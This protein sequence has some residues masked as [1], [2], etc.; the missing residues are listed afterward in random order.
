MGEIH[1][2]IINWE[3]LETTDQVERISMMELTGWLIALGIVILLLILSV[4]FRWMVMSDKEIWEVYSGDAV[5]MYPWMNRCD[6]LCESKVNAGGLNIQTNCNALEKLF[7]EDR[8]NDLFEWRLAVDDRATSLGCPNFPK[9]I[10]EIRKSSEEDIRK[11]KEQ[12]KQV[13][14]ERRLRR[15]KEI[16]EQPE[17]FARSL[18][19]GDLLEIISNYYQD[20]YDENTMVVVANESWYREPCRLQKQIVQVMWQKW[21]N[22][23]DPIHPNVPRIRILSPEGDVI[24][25]SPPA[26]AYPIWYEGCSY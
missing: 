24:G 6:P 23:R 7:R 3:D 8:S 25:G 10:E 9:D 22:I 2:H 1:S 14:E 12:I 21:V 4:P 13:Q 20:T 5:R 17:H 26:A 15:E 18:D 11:L 19:D 16:S